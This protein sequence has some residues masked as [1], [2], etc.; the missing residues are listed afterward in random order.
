M[1]QPN[2]TPQAYKAI[3]KAERSGELFLYVNDAA[4]GLPWVYDAF[5]S[6]NGGQA[7]VTVRLM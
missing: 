1:P 4:I 3:F 7:K 2:T 6:N 5:Y